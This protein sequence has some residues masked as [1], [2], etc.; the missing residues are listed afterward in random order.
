MKFQIQVLLILVTIIFSLVLCEKSIENTISDVLEKSRTISQRCKQDLKVLMERLNSTEES[1]WASRMIEATSRIAMSKSSYDYGDSG[2]YEECIQLQSKE[3]H[4]KGKYC[5]ADITY[6]YI[7]FTSEVNQV[8]LKDLTLRITGGMHM[9]RFP[10]RA[11]CLPSNCSD[12]DASY[13]MNKLQYPNVTIKSLMCQTKEEVYEPLDSNAYVGILI[14]VVIALVVIF[15]T[16]YDLYCQKHKKEKGKPVL[17]AFSIYTNGKKLLQTHNNR[18]S[19]LDC[20]DGI[21]VLSMTWVMT[22][23]MYVKYVAA[24]VFN[25]KESIQ[26]TGGILG[27][28]F[29]TGHLACDALFIVGGTLVTYVYFSRTKDGDITFYTI[30]KHYLH[31]YI[32]LTPA[33]I[34]VIIVVATLIKYTGSGPK[35]P[36]MDTLYQEGCQKYWWSTLLY[37]HN[38]V[39]LNN[40][41]VA[42]T[43]YIA[44]DTQL[45]II[46]PLI[47][48]LLK[49]HTKLGVICLTFAILGSIAL[50]FVKGYNDNIIPTVNSS[51]YANVDVAFVMFYFYLGTIARAAPWFMGTLLGYVLTRPRFQKPLSKVI[52]IPLWIISLIVLL[53]CALGNHPAFRLEQY[54]RFE[55]AIFS[56]L[57]RP[58]FAMAVGWV[59][60]ACATNQGGIIN[61]I[62]SWSVFNYINKFIY[63]MYLLHPNMIDIIVY[64]QK[65]VI[66]FSIFNMILWFWGIFVLVFALS[67]VWVLVFEIPPVILERLAFAKIESKSKSKEEIVQKDP[68]D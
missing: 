12:A 18:T 14:L 49:K 58:S 9:L 24:P 19:S 7:N 13:L 33:V 31:R 1:T 22:F 25:S 53:L 26:I 50:S 32:R 23:H 45:Y 57:V 5:I 55:N 46:S 35:W 34:G 17:V 27:I 40:M 42:H 51:Y 64:S 30:I 48:Y 15:A 52:L 67:L 62:L 65:S 16:M 36:V 11:I 37:I 39:Y 61:R 4:I 59:I 10:T 60:W 28:L 38:E 47:F 3:D 44:V 41:C 66:Y 6:N 20:L 43:W 68:T 54:S 8:P 63:S 56:S 29:T 21:R 2:H